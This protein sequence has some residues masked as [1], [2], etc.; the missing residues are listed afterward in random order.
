MLKLVEDFHATGNA[1]IH[2]IV[3]ITF[4]TLTYK[5]TSSHNQDSV[6][7]KLFLNTSLLSEI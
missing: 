3:N 1:E 4:L 2:S 7:M 5:E 6:A